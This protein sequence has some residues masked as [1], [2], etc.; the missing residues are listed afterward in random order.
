MRSADSWCDMAD[1]NEAMKVDISA[2]T[3]SLAERIAAP[4]LLIIPGVHDMIAALLA[5]KAGFDVLY[6][7]GFWLTASAHGLPDAG[8]IGFA[9]MHER[10][11]RLVKVSGA[12]VIA[13]GDTGYGGLLNVHHTIRGFEEAGVA[14]IQIEDQ[15]F[16]KKCGHTPNRQVIP[17]E[18]MADKI[19]VACEARRSTDT[20]IIA[21]TDAR[22]SE[23]LEKAIDRA[24]LYREAGADM[25]F[26]EALHSEDEMRTACREI[27]GPTMANMSNGGYTPMLGAEALRDIGYAAAIYPALS[28]LAAAHA[29][30][31]AF[32]ELRDRGDPRPEHVEIADFRTFCDMIGFPEVWA[33]DRKWAR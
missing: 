9:E 10:I 12:T 11:A 19:R 27:A 16:P 24:Q 5:R 15:V 29:I 20:L 6:G 17:A 26:V 18:E 28:G 31:Q 8:I 7:S 30:E 2:K 33:F 14:A 1:P 4:E 13:D 21:R 3:P 32:I 25:L 23:G 22:D